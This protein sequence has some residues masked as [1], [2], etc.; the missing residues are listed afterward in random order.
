M[1]GRR[2]KRL[3]RK[4]IS[5]FLEIKCTGRVLKKRVVMRCFFRAGSWKVRREK[6][7]ILW[8]DFFECALQKGEVS[9]IPV[10]A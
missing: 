7:L 3:V 1:V 9:L 10:V 6:G 8:R 5:D 2:L 4:I